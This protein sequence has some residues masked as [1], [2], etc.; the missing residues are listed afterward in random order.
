GNN[1]IR[2]IA[3]DGTVTTIAGDGIAGFTDG[4]GMQARF[5]APRSVA[6]DALGTI[7]VADTSNAAVR[8]IAPNGEV[9]TLVGDGTIGSND[10]PNARFDGLA[11]VAVDGN[12]VYVYLADTGNHRIRRLDPSGTVIT[13]TGAERGFADGTASQARFAEPSGIAIDGS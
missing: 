7:Y 1:R 8:R 9:K 3:S 4:T 13:I 11:G 5:N 12:S 10:S 6:A 2:R